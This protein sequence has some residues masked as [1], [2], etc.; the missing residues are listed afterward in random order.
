MNNKLRQL[1]WQIN[2]RKYNICS[3]K[4]HIILCTKIKF[5]K[6]NM[7]FI[8]LKCKYIINYYIHNIVYNNSIYNSYIIYNIV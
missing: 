6:F 5:T 3:H 2:F 8:L 4:K 1:K 7:V